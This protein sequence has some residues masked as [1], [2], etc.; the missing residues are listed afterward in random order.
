MTSYLAIFT[1]KTIKSSFFNLK[2]TTIPLS[3]GLMHG[4]SW[5]LGSAML[6]SVNNMYFLQNDVICSHF[7]VPIL[8]AILKIGIKQIFQVGLLFR[9]IIIVS[10]WY[11]KMLDPYTYTKDIEI[12]LTIYFIYTQIKLNKITNLTKSTILNHVIIQMISLSK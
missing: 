1:I 2:M 5:F 7:L 6:W 10:L 3:V 8:V 12:M 11:L 4:S 9:G